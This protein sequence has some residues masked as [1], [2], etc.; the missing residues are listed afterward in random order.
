MAGG[1]DTPAAVYNDGLV[2]VTAAIC[3]Q[4]HRLTEISLFL[5]A[6]HIE[7]GRID[8]EVKNGVLFRR[9]RSI[10]GWW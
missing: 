10:D 6:L 3:E 8:N 4:T 2:V 7:C 1:E 9:K 5:Q